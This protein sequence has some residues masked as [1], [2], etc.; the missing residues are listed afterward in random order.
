MTTREIGL[1]L[2]RQWFYVMVNKVYQI[3]IE[4]CNVHTGGR[5]ISGAGAD[6]TVGK[7]VNYRIKFTPP[8]KKK[9]KE[10]IEKKKKKKRKKKKKKKKK[11]KKN[12]NN[13]ERPENIVQKGL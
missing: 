7:S 1:Y 4:K 13:K 10:K 11:R 2:Y 3:N 8:K 9:K 5:G 6:W 12:L